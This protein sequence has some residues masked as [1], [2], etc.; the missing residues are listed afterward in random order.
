MP[1][2]FTFTFIATR[3][4][5]INILSFIP[6]CPFPTI[7]QRE[8]GEK[9]WAKVWAR[10]FT[11]VRVANPHRHNH[12]SKIIRSFA[13][14]PPFRGTSIRTFTGPRNGFRGREKLAGFI[15]HGSR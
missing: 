1:T 7:E 11:N 8:K 15:V 3:S 14:C 6:Y 13:L 4:T 9:G 12:K 5:P 10:E 2:T